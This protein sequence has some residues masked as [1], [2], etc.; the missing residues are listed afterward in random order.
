MR[1]FR[2]AE[3]VDKALEK[4]RNLR[5]QHAPDCGPSAAEADLTPGARSGEPST[6]GSVAQGPAS[7]SG[8]DGSHAALWKAAVVG[9]RTFAAGSC[10]SCRDPAAVARPALLRSRA[11]EVALTQLTTDPGVETQPSLSP[12]GGCWS[13]SA[14]AGSPHIYLLRVGGKNPI[15]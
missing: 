8:L 6:A 10:R 7:A 15:I 5:Y 11:A 3:I 14:G 1:S 4:D 13:T 9:A 12:D 2:E